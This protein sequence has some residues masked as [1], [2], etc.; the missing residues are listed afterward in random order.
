MPTEI[1]KIIIKLKRKFENTTYVAWSKNTKASLTETGTSLS[2]SSAAGLCKSTCLLPASL[3]IVVIRTGLSLT[4]FRKVTTA[5]AVH[6]RSLSGSIPAR[7]QGMERG[8]ILRRHSG[9]RRTHDTCKNAKSEK[10]AFGIVDV[11]LDLN[12]NEYFQHIAMS[13]SEVDRVSIT[14]EKI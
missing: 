1:K 11:Q 13:C 9:M 8:G 5:P 4:I 14:A 10:P 3:A 2:M 7:E 6:P 12:G